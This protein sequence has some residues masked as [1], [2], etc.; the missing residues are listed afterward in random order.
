M[1][2]RTNRTP[3][4]LT[5]VEELLR[6]GGERVFP[7]ELGVVLEDQKHAGIGG[8]GGVC[9]L[10]PKR[11]VGERAP[12]DARVREGSVSGPEKGEARVG[13]RKATAVDLRKH[14]TWQRVAVK[15]RIRPTPTCNSTAS[16]RSKCFPSF[17]PTDAA[18]SRKVDHLPQ[19]GNTEAK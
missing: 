16:K 2:A 15:C 6:C 4:T 8:V 3:Q 14:K 17:I 7:E 11:G 1:P 19:R 18:D 12:D 9:E 10:R 13:G 5:E